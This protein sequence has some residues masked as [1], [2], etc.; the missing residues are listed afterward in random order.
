MC[1]AGLDRAPG[2]AGGGGGCRGAVDKTGGFLWF[3]LVH[4]GPEGPHGEAGGTG[5]APG[6]SHPRA[7]TRHRSLPAGRGRVVGGARRGGGRCG[8]AGRRLPVPRDRILGGA[9]HERP[10]AAGAVCDAGGTGRGAVSA[11][12]RTEGGGGTGGSADRR[13]HPVWVPAGRHRRGGA[14]GG[15]LAHLAGR[16]LRILR[17]PLSDGRPLPSGR[18]G[19]GPGL[20]AGPAWCHRR[21]RTEP[22]RL[23]PQPLQRSRC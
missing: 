12:L 3:H 15:G 20:C 19:T 10:A 16:G 9:L 6:F 17:H 8:S 22:S 11:R 4:A 5:S 13:S 14:S 7:G 21:R 23:S 2:R 1:Q 18:D